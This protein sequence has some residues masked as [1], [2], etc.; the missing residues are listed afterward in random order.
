MWRYNMRIMKLQSV[1]RDVHC[2]V[3]FENYISALQG[4]GEADVKVYSLITEKF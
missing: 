3:Y 2:A 4:T 1:R